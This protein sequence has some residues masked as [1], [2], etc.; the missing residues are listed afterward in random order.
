MKIIVNMKYVCTALTGILLAGQAVASNDDLGRAMENFRRA[1]EQARNDAPGYAQDSTNDLLGGLGGIMDLLAGLNNGAAAGELDVDEMQQQVSAFSTG[2]LGSIEGIQKQAETAALA[3]RQ[4]NPKVMAL[5][6]DLLT[7]VDQNNFDQVQAIL[8]GMK[9]FASSHPTSNAEVIQKA[10]LKARELKF[11][12]LIELMLL[13]AG[14]VVDRRDHATGLITSFFVK[15]SA[16][17]DNECI[18]YMLKSKVQFAAGDLETALY[19]ACGKCN[20]PMMQLLMNG[21]EENGFR[22]ATFGFSDFLGQLEPFLTEERGREA[23]LY[24]VRN[25]DRQFGVGDFDLDYYLSALFDLAKE[26]GEI[27]LLEACLSRDRFGPIPY[28]DQYAIHNLYCKFMDKTNEQGFTAMANNTLLMNVLLNRTVNQS[29]LSEDHVAAIMRRAGEYGLVDFIRSM[30]ERDARF[31]RPTEANLRAALN[32]ATIN[33]RQAVIDY[34]QPLLPAPAPAPIAVQHAVLRANNYD[35]GGCLGIHNYATAPVTVEESK[36]KSIRLLDAVLAKVTDKCMLL[37][38]EDGVFPETY[39]DFDTASLELG[40]WID[41]FVPEA[42]RQKARNAAF[43]KL[44]SDV[45]YE[46]VLTLVVNYLNSYHPEGIELWIA[47]FI[48]ESISAYSGGNGVSCD[49]G[50]RERVAVGL[51]GIDAEL[52]KLFVQVEGP[53]MMANTI[54]KWNPAGNSAEVARHLME[55]GLPADAMAEDAVEL[56]IRLFSTDVKDNGLSMD[57]FADAMEAISEG[58]RENFEQISAALRKAN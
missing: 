39:L 36:N 35:V 22:A 53:A 51:R 28:P 57:D 3:E 2:L 23:K 41:A 24:L 40:D 8:E 50:I 5:H 15:A 17:Q 27:H 1:T 18:E 20:L 7:C 29:R 58:I 42:E 52:D 37:K 56:F 4:C 34:L 9:E 44:E 47:A 55:G 54:K 14:H 43:F 45:D 11:Y 31:V 6:N 38:D 13:N 32:Q 33:R 46:K 16:C 48:R 12:P 30:V 26:T 25:A 49:R 21:F 10:C 19:N